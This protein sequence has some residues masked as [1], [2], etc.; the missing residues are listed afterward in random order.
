MQLPLVPIAALLF[1]LASAL[2]CAAT[3]IPRRGAPANA[4]LA[5]DL[6]AIEWIR[7]F[8]RFLLSDTQRL[9]IE[10]GR[11]TLSLSAWTEGR[12]D[13]YVGA[14]GIASGLG[15]AA[16]FALMFGPLGALLGIPLVIGGS[17]GVTSYHETQAAR[18]RVKIQRAM[19]YVLDLLVLTIRSGAS[20]QLA[21]HR[22]AEDCANHPLGEELRRTL[23]DVSL[24][25]TL[26]QSMS[27]LQ[28]RVGTDEVRDLV[29]AV[30]L[31]EQLGRPIADALETLSE[32][33]RVHRTQTAE[34][35]AGTAGVHIIL[36]GGLILFVVLLLLFSPH[37][38]RWARG[39]Y[40]M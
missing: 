21:M 23:D 12:T 36:P 32:R 24:G 14:A 17:V 29:D 10:S 18:R 39:D 3:L 1:G 28:N 22:V 15:S 4:S 11:R 34:A 31:A 8:G 26:A 25:L 19:P 27:D 30:L 16:L 6:A 40:S 20:L 38:V 7:R 9:R 5:D 13:G 33:Q 35:A 2:L 37:I